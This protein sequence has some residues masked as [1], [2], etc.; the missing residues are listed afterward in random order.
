MLVN[1]LEPHMNT[2]L[3]L[4]FSENRIGFDGA[5]A[6]GKALANMKNIE[7]INLASNLLGDLAINEVL[8]GL[9][10]SSNLKEINFSNNWLGQKQNE[11]EF[12]T[13]LALIMANHQLEK[14]DLSWNNLK[15]KVAENLIKSLK[16]NYTLK[17]LNL[18]YNLFGVSDS[19][20]PPAAIKLADM[21]QE[22]PT[23]EELNL[24]NNLI[25]SKVAF[26]LAYGLRTN[27]S[28]KSFIIDGNPIGSSGVKFLIQSINNNESGKVENIKMKD[29][30]TII[31]KNKHALFDPMNVEGEHILELDNVYDRITLY[32]LLDIDEKIAQNSPQDDGI[33]QGECFLEAKLG[34]S[35]WTPPN[36][37]DKDGRWDLGPEPS[38]T[39]KFRYS[40]DP[41][42]N[43]K[44]G[45]KDPELPKGTLVDSKGVAK[46]VISEI[47]LEKSI[48][49]LIRLNIEESSEWQREMINSLAQEHT[50]TYVQAKEL[51]KAVL[52]E[53]RIFAVV[54]LFNRIANRHLRYD[55]IQTLST[56]DSK[57]LAM[58]YLAG[59]FN[60]NYYNPTDHYKLKL[61]NP[62][63]REVALT[64]LMFNRK[65]KFAIDA[66]EAT[67]RSKFGNRSWFRNEKLDGV[68]FVYDQN[69][70]LPH[71]GI[72]ECDFV[73]VT[74]APHKEEKTA[75]DKLDMIKDLLQ[76]LEG[77]VK[78]QIKSFKALSEYLVLSS[79]QLGGLVDLIDDPAWKTEW[80]MAGI[81][82][83]YDQRNFDFI[84]KKWK[85]P[86]TSRDIYNRFGIFNLFSPHKWTGSYRL[87]LEIYEERCVC[88]IL[89]ELAKAE[90]Y[91]YMTNV[92]M[93]S[94][95]I[96]EINAEFEKNLPKEGIFEGSYVPPEDAANNEARER[97]GKKYFNWSTEDNE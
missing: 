9:Q 30:D 3:Q 88:Q 29:T 2:L 82:R 75:E 72:F 67:D 93:N 25:E 23:L 61:G 45:P 44:P 50:F 66:G 69:F 46:P 33:Q 56:Y 79:R 87:D 83:M 27:T 28:L 6:L 96:A 36:Q 16:D 68:S 57:L 48:D 97:V 54:T 40:L 42:R 12:V 43:Q 1:S 10:Q 4:N 80:Y 20:E 19:E 74:T 38:G 84:K 17:Y 14:L 55:L 26:C 24:S 58:K 81:G 8:I 41:K 78:Q 64:L 59:S 90:G 32:H 86:E 65:A 85:Y 34:S 51:L 70:I 95:P 37:K 15:G 5:E 60:F 31:E 47:A 53:D 7:S 21:L 39:L 94:K 77:N 89:L 92:T 73:Y 62:V 22:N 71:F 11:C 91:Q 52:E 49:L 76:S 13:N 35:A 18:S 63:E